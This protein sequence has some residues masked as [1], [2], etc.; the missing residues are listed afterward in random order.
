M[1]A[2]EARSVGMVNHVVPRDELQERVLELAEKIA[3]RPLFA[4]K[5][6][7][8]AVNQSQDAQGQWQAMEA[9]FSLHQLCHSHNVQVHKIPVNP[10]GLLPPPKKAKG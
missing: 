10:A 6:S 3:S 5:M 4:L 8:Q 1:S 2:V 7:K 9:A